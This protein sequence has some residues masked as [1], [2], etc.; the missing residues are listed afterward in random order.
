MVMIPSSFMV[1]LFLIIIFSH[2]CTK[3][4]SILPLA[5]LKGAKEKQENLFRAEAQ[6]K[7]IYL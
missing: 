2:S 5:S 7:K 4:N 6:G 1:V 3:T